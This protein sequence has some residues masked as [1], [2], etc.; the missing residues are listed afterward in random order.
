MRNRVQFYLSFACVLAFASITPAKADWLTDRLNAAASAVVSA[1][2][3]LKPTK[4]KARRATPQRKRAVRKKR[5]NAARIVNIV[6]VTKIVRSNVGETFGYVASGAAGARD[7]VATIGSNAIRV[8]AMVGSSV[9][10]PSVAAALAAAIR[11]ARATHYAN[12]KPLPAEV[13]ARL[14]PTMP[15]AALRRARYVETDLSVTLPYVVNGV[16]KYFAGHDHAVVVDDVIVFTKAPGAVDK[17]DIEWWAHEVHHVHQYMV[18]G[19]DRF[20]ARY[21]RDS[22]YIEKRAGT[23]AKRATAHAQMRKERVRLSGR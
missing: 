8:P 16:Q 7:F 20:A 18:W 6:K 13:I 10:A 2:K 14:A 3:L 1:P 21:V 12:S 4:K 19:I 17:E 23:V 22:G 5:P 15:M 11:N 9:P